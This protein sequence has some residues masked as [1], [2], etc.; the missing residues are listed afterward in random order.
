MIMTANTSV[1]H[2]ACYSNL[3]QRHPPF[4]S[5]HPP[6]TLLRRRFSQRL[7]KEAA[8][9]PAAAA[10]V[11]GARAAGPAGGGGAAGADAA[12]VAG[13]PRGVASASPSAVTLHALRLDWEPLQ[14][15]FWPAAVADA[16]LGL[17]NGDRGLTLQEGECLRSLGVAGGG[18]VIPCESTPLGRCRMVTVTLA[19]YACFVDRTSNVGVKCLNTPFGD[20][21]P[22]VECTDCFCLECLAIIE[23]RASWVP[24]L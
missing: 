24:Q 21:Q 3:H 4:F 20:V 22:L 11:A 8:A 1:S 9:S 2:S 18:V 14:L 6:C 5:Q 16:L 17:V 13:G 10:A 23:R 15:R 7:V 12:A 19:I